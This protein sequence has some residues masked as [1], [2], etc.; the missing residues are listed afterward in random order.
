MYWSIFYATLIKEL[1]I[2]VMSGAKSYERIVMSFTCI[3]GDHFAAEPLIDENVI[4]CRDYLEKETTNP[5]MMK[6]THV[7][8]LSPSSPGLYNEVVEIVGCNKSG[9]S[10]FEKI[11]YAT[12]CAQSLKRITHNRY[13]TSTRVTDGWLFSSTVFTVQPCPQLSSNPATASK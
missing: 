2:P 8:S 3:A 11:D 6:L 5:Y 9:T 4:L 12:A 1:T 7:P 10:S 13:C